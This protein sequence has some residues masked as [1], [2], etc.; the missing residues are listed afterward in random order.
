MFGFESAT[1]DTDSE[2][3]EI[4]SIN[5]ENKLEEL[6]KGI[7]G[8]T[9]NIKQVPPIYSAVKVKG[10]RLY[11]Y[12]RQ[13]KEVELPI[14]DVA[15]NNFKLISYEGNKGK[16]MAT[17]SKGTYIRSLIVDLAKSI[18]TKAVVSSINRIEIGTLNKNNAKVIK[19]IEQLER[20]NTP[21]PLDWRILFDLPIISVQDDDLN[22]IK[23]GNFLK[24]SLF[25]S[26]GPHIIENNN[27]IVAI[28]EP[29]NENKFKPQK[30][31]I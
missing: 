17:V 20:R 19:N 28:Y 12:A 9:G 5:L 18:E 22:D 4:E 26:D 25:E 16:F 14:R 6:N 2:L 31:L 8:L 24:S 7:S 1:N 15:I 3:V 23:N 27:S 21:D 10:K 30:V 13:E 11:K 29:Y